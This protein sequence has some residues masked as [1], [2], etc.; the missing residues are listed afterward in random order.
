MAVPL[1]RGVWHDFI[2]DVNWSE[3]PS[4]GYYRLWYDGKEVVTKTPAATLMSGGR[5]GC[6]L[7]QGLYRNA[8]VTEVQRVYHTG[9]TIATQLA[10]VLAST[11]AA[12]DAG[13]AS[14]TKPLMREWT[15]GAART[16]RQ[17]PPRARRTPR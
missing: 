4:V 13:P 5:G 17:Q 11:T 15:Q 14:G 3:D 6:Y 7:K 16:R 12:A 1:E 9:M 10:D 8:D 2:I